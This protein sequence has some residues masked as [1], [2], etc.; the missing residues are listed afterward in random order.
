MARLSAVIQQSVGWF[1]KDLAGRIANRVINTP[2]SVKRLALM[3]LSDSA[4]GLILVLGTFIVLSQMNIYM[5]VP[6]LIWVTLYVALTRWT[7]SKVEPLSNAASEAKS[8]VSGV[9][10]DSLTNIHAVKS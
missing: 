1:E 8:T 7:I 4:H 5:T 9:I 10:I 2:N 6:L 3:T